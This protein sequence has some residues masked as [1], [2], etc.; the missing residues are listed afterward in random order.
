MKIRRLA[1]FLFA[2]VL[3]IGMVSIPASADE[4]AKLPSTGDDIVVSE[5]DA[6]VGYREMD[7]AE[8][9]EEGLAIEDI[10]YVRSS[11]IEDELLFRKTRTL[12]ELRNYYGYSEED[13][14]LLMEYEGERIESNPDLQALTGTLTIFRP[15][16]LNAT[17]TRISLEVEWEWDQKPVYTLTDALAISWVGTYG[18]DNG[19]LRFDVNAS[20]H[21]VTYTGISSVTFDRGFVQEDLLYGVAGEFDMMY[22]T[23]DWA[24]SGVATLYWNTVA[25]S[26]NLTSV[27]FRILYGH[28]ITAWGPSFYWPPSFGLAPE[29]GT[30]EA[31][32]RNGYVNISSGR[33]V[34]N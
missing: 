27:D 33:W 12:E 5:Y 25:G 6:I 13:I 14:A 4:T 11:A 31:D 28:S 26:G 21:N 17:R 19:N 18:S 24:S 34:D 8:L 29:A 22:G 2:T 1:C 7:V 16:V 3:L 23:Y 9:E 32:V 30:D 20:S 10:E 15:R